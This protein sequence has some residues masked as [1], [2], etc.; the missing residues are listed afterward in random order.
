MT[1]QLGRFWPLE[2]CKYPFGP[3]IVKIEVRSLANDFSDEFPIKIT[4]TFGEI[5]QEIDNKSLFGVTKRNYRIR[6]QYCK[7]IYTLVGCYIPE[8]TKYRLPVQSGA[9]SEKSQIRLSD[10]KNNSLSGHIDVNAKLEPALS[11]NLNFGSGISGKSEKDN[12]KSREIEVTSEINLIEPIPN[13]WAIGIDGIGDPYRENIQYCLRS[14]YFDH[15]SDK[16]PATCTV[17]F[18]GTAQESMLKFVISARGGLYVERLDT[19]GRPLNEIHGKLR[20]QVVETMRS[21]IAGMV[22]ESS[23][24][25]VLL[26]EATFRAER[27]LDAESLDTNS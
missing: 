12:Q 24:K 1:N 18:D 22:L 17:K 10:R 16:Y 11:G 2:A 4:T 13:G 26:A 21:K 7:L 3:D 19:G 6:V 5:D 25:G 9:F 20:A 15:P 23:L 14:C 8:D 27:K